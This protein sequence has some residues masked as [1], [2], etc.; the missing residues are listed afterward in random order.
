[1]ADLPLDPPADAPA[2]A[3][4][5]VPSPDAPPADALLAAPLIAPVPREPTSIMYYINKC[6]SEIGKK[7][8]YIG[9]TGVICGIISGYA[10]H[11]GTKVP[12]DIVKNHTYASPVSGTIAGV[13][14]GSIF[15]FFGVVHY[16]GELAT[17]DRI[18]RI[19]WDG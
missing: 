11:Q 12:F 1:M 8:T 13:F 6:F 17:V 10:A 3:P 15:G 14:Y 7:A 5:D 18:V 16:I 9:V 2:D 19:A 4:P